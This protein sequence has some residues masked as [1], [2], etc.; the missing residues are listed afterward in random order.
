MTDAKLQKILVVLSGGMDSTTL[1]YHLKDQGHELRALGVDY[2]Q[3]H[4]RELDAARAICDAA[5]IP[6]QVADLTALNPLMG[7]SALTDPSI[8]VPEG[9]YAAEN[10]KATVVPNR[11][12]L[13]IAVSLS[14]C[15]ALGYDA[16][17]YAAHAGDHTIYPDC[18]PEFAAVMDAAAHLCDFEPRRLL[19]PFVTWTKADIAARGAELGV[20]YDV[21]WTCYQGGAKHCGRCGT[22]VERIEAFRLGG[23]EDPTDYEV[24]PEEVMASL[25]ALEASAGL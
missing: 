9:H 6:F 21:T 25:P 19:R 14:H 17:A 11:N 7:G 18:R 22:C 5:G 16:V 3:R 1:L 12:M 4:R 8:A 23:V 13:L 2:G 24:D 10:M 20:P 15:V